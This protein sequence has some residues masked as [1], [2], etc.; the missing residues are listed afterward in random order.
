MKFK[1]HGIYVAILAVLIRAA[2]FAAPA[3]DV[4][5]IVKKIRKTYES[6]HT[7][8]SEFVQSSIWALAGEEHKSEG[9]IYLA[10]KNR[11]RVETDTQ[12]LVTDG[13]YVWTYAKDRNQVIIDK[14]SGSKENPLPKDI[15]LK[16]TKDS[17]AELLGEEEIGGTP[18]YKLN[19]RPDD[20]NA[21]IVRTTVWV[22]RRNW[23][24]VK[25]EQED[26]NENLTRYLLRHTKVNPPLPDSLFTF[27]VPATA[28]TVDLR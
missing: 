17:R 10:E 5:K 16:Y 12:I 21:F 13:K 1:K 9:K 14:L 23:L 8:E 4:K 25:I 24:A 15:L 19:F 27:S 26:I 18:C 3:D 20:E 11:Y 7:L 22:N 6:I 28:E 2:G